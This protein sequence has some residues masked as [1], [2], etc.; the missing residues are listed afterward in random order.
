MQETGWKVVAKGEGVEEA[1]AEA[2]SWTWGKDRGPGPV[3][4]WEPR[5]MGWDGRRKAWGHH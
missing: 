1:E 5:E 3:R 4:P 2:W